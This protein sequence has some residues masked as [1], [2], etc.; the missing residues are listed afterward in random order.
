M[1]NKHNFSVTLYS[2]CAGVNEIERPLQFFSALGRN[3]EPVP[4]APAEER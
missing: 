4:T 1:K 2:E 3:E